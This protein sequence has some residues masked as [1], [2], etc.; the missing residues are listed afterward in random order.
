METICGIDEAGRGPLAGPV[1]A[2]AV[3][4]NPG[5]DTS[6][7][8][9]SKKLSKQKRHTAAAYI[10]N[11]SKRWNIGWAWPEEIDLINIHCA[12]LLAMKRAFAGITCFVDLVLVDGKFAPAI[13]APC[14]P[15]IKGDS[16]V[17]EIMAASIVA[18]VSRDRWMERYSW[19]E[20]NYGFDRHKGYPTK[21]HRENCFRYGLSPIH[22]RSFTIRPVIT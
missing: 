7:L 8:K 5:F 1:T 3:V 19:I 11:N 14:Q 22:R 18:K 21:E 4:L 13:S 2:A 9:D 20:P 10:M 15:I 6:L 16:L 17:Y 12:S